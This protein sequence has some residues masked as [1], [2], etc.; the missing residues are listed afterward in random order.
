MNAKQTALGAYLVRTAV[1]HAKRGRLHRRATT[2]SVTTPM[3]SIGATTVTTGGCSSR[4]SA[5]RQV[6]CRPIQ[7]ADSGSAQAEVCELALRPVSECSSR[8]NDSYQVG[9]NFRSWLL[10][11]DQPFSE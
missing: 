3:P 2:T 8:F 9:A 10:G 6:T 7:K 5:E 1:I 11:D 4:Y